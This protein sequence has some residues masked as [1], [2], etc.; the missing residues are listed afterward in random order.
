MAQRQIE[1]RSTREIILDIAKRRQRPGSGSDRTFLSTRTATM[2][3]INLTPILSPI[4]WAV[5]GAVATR[6]YMPE[7]LTKDLDVIINRADR[8]EARKKLINA[9]FVF[10][11]ELTIGGAVWLA[12]TKDQIDVIEGDQPWLEEALH[13]SQSNRDQQGLPILPFRFLVLLKFQSGRVQDL[14]DITRMLGQAD[15][16]TLDKTRQVFQSYEPEGI[17]DLESMITLGKLEMGKC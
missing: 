1:V 16:S 2:K 13:E 7:R 6:H 3:W 10:Q 12:P 5:I 9:G 8:S 11:N 17:R 4:K 14:A 15:D